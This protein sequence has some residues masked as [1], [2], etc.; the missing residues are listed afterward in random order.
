MPSAGPNSVYAGGLW[1]RTSY[2]PVMQRAAEDALRDGLRRYEGGRGWRDPG[3]TVD[4]IARLALAARR[5]PVRRRLRGLA[6]RGRDLQGRRQRHDRLH[7]RQHRHAARPR[8]PRCRSATAPARRSARCG[9]ARSSPS[10]ARAPTGR[11]ARSPKFRAG[12]SSRKWARGRILAMQGGFDARLSDFNRATQAMRQPGSTF[13]PIVYSAAL[14]NGMTPA[15]III[16]GPFCVNQ[17]TPTAEMLPQ[18]LGRLCRAADDALG[19]RAVAQPDDGA[20]R[21]PDRHA[22]ESSAA[23]ARWGSATITH[24]LSA[25]RARR[26]RHD[27]AADGQRLRDLRQPGPG[28]DADA[29]RLYPGPSRPRHLARRHRARATAAT[30]AETGTGK[31]DAAAAAAGPGRWSIR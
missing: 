3:L 4:M 29:D 27:G 22:A 7:R 17:G 20:R 2:D 24:A 26:R 25:D 10:S 6:R 15:S 21:R 5:R 31:A 19:P 28:A 11:C 8:S 13:K 23:H 1:V 18:L 9:P 14:D 30:R 16:D 12:W